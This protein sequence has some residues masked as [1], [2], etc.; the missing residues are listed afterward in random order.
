MTTGR[1]MEM[2]R[3]ESTEEQEAKSKKNK[4][5]LEQKQAGGMQRPTRRKKQRC[6]YLSSGLAG[7][8]RY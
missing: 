4:K 6:T 8:G 7:I 2:K 5:Q 3:T 1:M